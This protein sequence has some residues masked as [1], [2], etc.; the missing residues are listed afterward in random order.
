MRARPNRFLAA[1]SLMS[2]TVAM[3]R[4]LRPLPYRQTQYLLIRWLQSRKGLE[5]LSRFVAHHDDFFRRFGWRNAKTSQFRIETSPTG[6]R[7]V[8]MAD[9]SI[10]NRVKPWQGG[11]L[12]R[13][14]IDLPPGGEE[15]VSDRIVDLIGARPATAIRR[16]L[17][18]M[19]V[20]QLDEPGITRGHEQTLA[21][22]RVVMTPVCPASAIRD[23]LSL[24]IQER[25]PG[26]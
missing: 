20:V 14:F 11:R 22:G 15:G 4:W 16:D 1:S 23:I 21:H 19:T 2:S 8:L 25:A 18:V 9:D 12:L 10:G 26:R 6:S 7:P 5:H 24:R 3:S 17:A 13:D